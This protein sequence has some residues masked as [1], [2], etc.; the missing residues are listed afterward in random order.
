MG[1]PG[2]GPEGLTGLSVV[3]FN[4]LEPASI[5]LAHKGQLDRGSN[6]IKRRLLNQ[7]FPTTVGEAPVT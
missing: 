5:V 7:T 2:D 3:A 1:D 4:W 6:S